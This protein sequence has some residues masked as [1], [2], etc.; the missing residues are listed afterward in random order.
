[1]KKMFYLLT[2]LFF[3]SKPTSFG[4]TISIS[5][6]SVNMLLCHKWDIKSI[7]MGGQQINSSGETVTY[8][9]FK[10]SNFTRTTDKKTENGV[11]SYEQDKKWIHLKI[12]KKTHIYI[13]SLKEGEFQLTANNDK[14]PIPNNPFGIMVFFKIITE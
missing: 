12:K 10:D 14:E 5:Q 8:Q 13:M 9:F 6:D 4:Q 11:W 7:T 2:A 1:M 3:L